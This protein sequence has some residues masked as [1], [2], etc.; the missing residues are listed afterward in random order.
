VPFAER[1][2]RQHFGGA[3]YT[4]AASTMNANLEHV[5]LRVPAIFSLQIRLFRKPTHRNAG[6]FI[7]EVAIAVA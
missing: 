1:C 5:C 3:D 6:K 4:L 7:H 2:H